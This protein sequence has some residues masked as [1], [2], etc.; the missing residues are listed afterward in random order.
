MTHLT[1]LS[2][3]VIS[4]LPRANVNDA[5]KMDHD[6]SCPNPNQT[7]T[8]PVTTRQDWMPTAVM[9]APNEIFKF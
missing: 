8:A 2:V 9:A 1:A 6:D 7:A 3:H 5:A 4:I